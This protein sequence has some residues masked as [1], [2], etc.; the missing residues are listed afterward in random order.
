M[1]SLSDPLPWQ[2]RRQRRSASGAAAGAEAGFTLLEILIVLVILGLVAAVIAAP[3][4]FKY[5]GQA[6]TEAAKVQT[7]RIAGALD[8]FR[9]EVGRY[10][11]QQENLDAL[12]DPPP[13]VPGWNGPYLKKREAIIDPWGHEFHY[14]IPGQYGDYDLYSLGKDNAVG[15][16]G[17]DRD[18]TNY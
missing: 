4:V 6:K 3:Q 9:L 8:L 17:E 14:R 1:N 10:P 15:G 2:R 7:E 18:I 12:V 13:G 16:E 5:L 11:T